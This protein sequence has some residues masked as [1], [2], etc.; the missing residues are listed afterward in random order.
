[1]SNKKRYTVTFDAYLWARNDREAMVKAAKVAEFLQTL[2][3]N[4]ARVLK[5]EET[6]FASFNTRTVHEGRLTLFENKLI[7]V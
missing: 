5:L 1:M 2:E 4:Q 7:E 6:P 3:D